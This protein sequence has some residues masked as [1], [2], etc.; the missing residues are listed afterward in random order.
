MTIKK[1]AIFGVGRIAETVLFDIKSNASSFEV[2]CFVVDAG[3]LPES[4]VL[5]GI[6]IRCWDEFVLNPACDSLFVAIGYF[7]LNRQR[8]RVCERVRAHGIPLANIN[9]REIEGINIVGDNVFVMSSATLQAPVEIHSNAMIFGGS[10]V[11]HHSLLESNT[12]VTA[13]AT[14][15][16]GS[17][18]G[19]NVFLAGG[20]T[21]LPNSQI[22][23]FSII[24][25]N[26]LVGGVVPEKSVFATER[27][28]VHRLDSENFIKLL[29]DY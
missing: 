10:T 21:V 7:D 18:L 17:T 27:A 1:L 16:G 12:W 3:S 19:R 2:V 29:K 4:R 15:L 23:A 6:P 25:A 26:T 5:H 14:I 13:G 11:C 9:L 20:A 8:Q 28:S 24:G 22:G